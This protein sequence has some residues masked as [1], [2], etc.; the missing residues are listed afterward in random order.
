MLI[1]TILS[2]QL[3]VISGIYIIIVLFFYFFIFYHRTD[4]RNSR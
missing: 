3:L 2:V 4:S 1:Q